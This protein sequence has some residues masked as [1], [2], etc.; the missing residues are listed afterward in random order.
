MTP[1]ADGFFVLARVY[2]DENPDE[3]LTSTPIRMV[4]VNGSDA[5]KALKDNFGEKLKVLGIPRVD[6]AQVAE[7]ANTQP[8]GEGEDTVC[9]PYEIIVLAVLSE[10]S[11]PVTP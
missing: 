1:L 5:A 9:L 3:P 11:P 2:D 7:I 6:L 10:E 4:F 8:G